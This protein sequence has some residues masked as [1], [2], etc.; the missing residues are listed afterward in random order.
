M[1]STERSDQ[2][3]ERKKLLKKVKLTR[4]KVQSAYLEKKVAKK[5]N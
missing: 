3:R 1:H 4:E 2:F 5:G